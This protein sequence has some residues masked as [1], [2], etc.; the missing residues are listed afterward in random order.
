MNELKR[1]YSFVFNN[2]EK[3]SSP[4]F[5][6]EK[7]NNNMFVWNVKY[8]KKIQLCLKR[9]NKDDVATT[10][11]IPR[12]SVNVAVWAYSNEICC[13]KNNNKLKRK[14]TFAYCSMLLQTFICFLFLFRFCDVFFS[15][16]SNYYCQYAGC[17]EIEPDW[18]WL[19]RHNNDF[20]NDSR[21]CESSATCKHKKY[22]N[23][24]R[25]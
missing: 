8:E 19:C 20:V 21:Q 5:V 2:N 9:K 16:S 13:Q 11:K 14:N 24:Q 25:L 6:E 1:I 10:K 15:S 17:L 7:M 18:C 12:Q 4:F 22:R 23:F 3:K